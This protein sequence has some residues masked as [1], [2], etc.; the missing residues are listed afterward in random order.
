MAIVE[1][2]AIQR[3]EV[4]YDA[5]VDGHLDVPVVGDENDVYAVELGGW[6]LG[7]TSPV[8][9]V[10]VWTPELA[11]HWKVIDS[12]SVKRIP[13]TIHRPDVIAHHP[14]AAGFTCGF[15]APLGIV[16][17][18][19]E[20]DWLLQVVL[21][22]ERRVPLATVRVKRQPLRSSF[23]PTLQPLLLTGLGR[24]GSSWVMRLLAEH[25]EI[26]VQRSFLDTRAIG[27]WMHM[28]RVLSQPASPDQSM[29]FATS[30]AWSVRQNPFYGPPITN[31]PN[32]RLWLGRGYPEQL[33]AFCQQ[34][35]EQLYL[36]TAQSQGQNQ[37]R[38]FAEKSD[39]SAAWLMQDLY[40]DMRE[41]F[42]VR[43]FRDLVA[44][45]LVFDAKRG[46]YGFGRQP[47]DSEADYIRRFQVWTIDL[48]Q[49]WRRRADRAHLLRYEDLVLN[50]VESI[51]RALEYL[52]VEAT[53]WL[54]RKMIEGANQDSAAWAHHRTSP[55]VLASIGRWRRDLAPAA[56]ELCQELFAD[57]LREFGYE[58]A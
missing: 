10:E 4:D 18:A 43:D 1:I 44:S 36:H 22:D 24:S 27:Y 12:A 41:I 48:C 53:P 23:E 52:N 32:T 47:E 50:P 20:F 35:V 38:Y 42:L 8:R 33:A 3:H 25:P 11:P 9:T 15:L 6:A 55:S 29:A 58:R 21:E 17:T 13:L 37:P 16:G 40:P 34:A 46:F 31:D 19:P 49:A 39:P 56:Q 7:R 2:M 45:I 5:L 54:V 28:A 26:V 57:A 51:Q 30:D 14:I